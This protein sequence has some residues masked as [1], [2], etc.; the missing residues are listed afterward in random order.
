MYND[1][2]LDAA[3]SQGVL[4][5]ES[6]IR[7][8]SFMAANASSNTV[9]E[10]NFRLISGFNDIF[11]SIAALILLIS[12]SWVAAQF[13]QLLPPLV[14]AIL[15][16]L[17]SVFFISHKRLALPAIMFLLAFVISVAGLTFVAG[18]ML[19]PGWRADEVVMLP[20]L[21]LLSGVLAAWVHWLKFKVPVTVA[22]GAATLIASVVV[23]VY[24][25]T[26]GKAHLREV[27]LLNPVLI[28]CG[29]A[30]FL[31]AMYWDA[32]D[33]T[34]RSR[35]SDVAF[36]LHLLAAPLI[37]HPIFA[38]LGILDGQSSLLGI[39]SIVMLYLLLGIISI[40]IDRRALMVSSLA[41]VLY[42]FSDLL[43]VYGVVSM[44]LAVSGLFIGTMLLLL[45]AYWHKTRSLVVG[46]LPA[47]LNQ[48]LPILG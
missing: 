1:N 26:D 46:A 15:S 23:G 43:E 39:V 2:D 48:Y 11:V 40:A 5:K 28:C 38:S 22:A 16:W 10:E 44:S 12:A 7:F 47:R 8:R 24:I 9:D 42:A 14:G 29:I 33:T 21:A 3:V 37:V 18:T 25:L 45:S 19:L 27:N 6:V 36:W 41:Y 13:H 30:T 32:Q 34:R 4:D 20:V 17:L 35:K 31:L